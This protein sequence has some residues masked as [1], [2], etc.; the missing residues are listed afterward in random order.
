MV[1]RTC[2]QSLHLLQWVDLLPQLLDLGLHVVSLCSCSPHREAST[3]S[4]KSGEHRCK[5]VWQGPHLW[6]MCALPPA[7]RGEISFLVR[8]GRSELSWSKEKQ[9]RRRKT[10]RP[11]RA[12]TVDPP[13]RDTGVH[14]VLLWKELNTHEVDEYIYSGPLCASLVTQHALAPEICYCPTIGK[15]WERWKGGAVNNE[16]PVSGFSKIFTRN[17]LHWAVFPFNSTNWKSIE[18]LTVK[19]FIANSKQPENGSRLFLQLYFQSLTFV[20]YL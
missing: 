3:Q 13:P 14:L 19:V 8:D 1:E 20:E 5:K 7:W 12:M 11:G 4:H 2:L 16:P 10:G 6:I 15:R 18:C 9:R 17:K